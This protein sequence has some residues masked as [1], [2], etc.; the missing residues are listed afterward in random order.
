[1]T[2]F[3][4]VVLENFRRP[5]N[6]GPLEQ[7][8]GDA[9]GANPLCGDRVR[10]QVRVEGDSIADARFTADACAVCVASASLLTEHVR[11]KRVTEAAELDARWLYAAL[12][13]EPPR[14]RE[15]CALLPLDTL[16]RALA[17][18]QSGA[19]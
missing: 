4:A 10:L 1:M 18:S 2:P 3:R 15:R 13:G 9:E 14:G 12:D 6:R 7:P 16:R 17:N 19:R 5:R 8:S 11:G